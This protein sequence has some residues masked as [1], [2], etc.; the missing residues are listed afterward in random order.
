MN[1]LWLMLALSKLFMLVI[2]IVLRLNLNQKITGITGANGEQD[3][4]IMVPSKYLSNFLRTLEMPLTNCEINLIFTW[5]DKSV[6]SNDT[7]ATTFTM[8]DT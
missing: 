2:I 7:N 4:E 5:S 1:Q 6:L 8:T 3:V